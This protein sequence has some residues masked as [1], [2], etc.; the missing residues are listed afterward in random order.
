MAIKFC[1][2]C[3]EVIE[4]LM[5]PAAQPEATAPIAPAEGEV[6]VVRREVTSTEK[7]RLWGLLPLPSRVVPIGVL[8]D[9]TQT[10]IALVCEDDNKRLWACVN[11]EVKMMGE[12]GMP[13]IPEPPAPP[14]A[15]AA[16]PAPA[17]APAQP[18]TVPQHICNSD[19]SA[20][21]EAR[22]QNRYGK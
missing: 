3:G 8:T 20:A 21:R 18:A 1:P 9:K 5:A 13:A 22:G 4:M 6:E 11:G 14:Q 7:D 19:C 16:T 2:H 12:L 15:A 10:V 17:P